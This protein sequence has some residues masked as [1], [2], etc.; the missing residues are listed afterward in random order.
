VKK[1]GVRDAGCGIRLAI[2]HPA[3]RIPAWFIPA[4]LFLTGC[5]YVGAPLPPLRNIPASVTDLAAAQHGARIIVHFTP[6]GKTTEGRMLDR[7]VKYDLR[8]GTAVAPFDPENWAA[9]ASELP[10]IAVR[11]GLAQTELPSA[12]WTGRDVTLAVRT[13]GSNG[14]PSG[15]SNFVNLTIVPPPQRPTA[16]HAEG[17]A[18]G[19]RLHWQGEA[20]D[21][22]VLRREGAEGGFAQVAEVQQPEWLDRTAEFGKPYT[23]LV[24]RIVKLADDRTAQSEL[25]EE[26][27]I[28]PK[29][30]YPPAAPRGLRVV[31]GPSSIELAW[32]RNTEPDL[33]GYRVYRS[34]AGGAWARLADVSQIP[35][36]SDHQVESGKTYQYAISA[37]DQAGNESPRSAAVE[38]AASL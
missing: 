27:T 34:A 30:V 35:A 16:L 24:Q 7:P 2:P 26:A 36:Y 9:R 33:A 18:D 22:V 11:N 15:W 4:V 29:D 17:T 10:P 19:V 25:S 20:G 28:T 5:G 1:L 3:S 23:Y 37:V 21:F 8:I 32:D 31:S 38:A 6:P 12:A 14:K 13:I